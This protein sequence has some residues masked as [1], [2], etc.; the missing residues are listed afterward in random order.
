ASAYPAQRVVY[1]TP[2]GVTCGSGCQQC[3]DVNFGAYP[4]YSF[5]SASAELTLFN[6]HYDNALFTLN[7]PNS[8]VAPRLIFGWESPRGLGLR[9]RFWWL[10]DHQ[11]AI[12]DAFFNQE[13]EVQLQARRFDFEVYRRFSFDGSSLA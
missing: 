2:A 6:P 8:V 3:L 1:A 10:N 12:S 11:V 5:W 7:D 13:F 4:A 9:A